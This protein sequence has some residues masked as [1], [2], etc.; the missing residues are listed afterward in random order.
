MG[1]EAA[2]TAAVAV[3][4]AVVPRTKLIP[5]ASTTRERTRLRDLV[6][7][8]IRVSFGKLEPPVEKPVNLTS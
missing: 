2:A 6:R 7:N 3:S 5:I 1:A 4:F 8:F